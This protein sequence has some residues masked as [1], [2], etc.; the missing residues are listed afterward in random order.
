MD[1]MRDGS[2]QE[3]NSL[4]AGLLIHCF[5]KWR[6]FGETW[7]HSFDQNLTSFTK[8]TETVMSFDNEFGNLHKEQRS[9]K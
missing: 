4:G 1:Q 6:M 7:L 3:S 9:R 2:N 5:K 8:Q